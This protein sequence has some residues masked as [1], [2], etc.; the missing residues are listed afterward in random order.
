M[1]VES[2]L[3]EV[4][5]LTESEGLMK[6]CEIVLEV[7]ET[8]LNVSI[9]VKQIKQVI[10][11]M[12]KNAMDAIE[13]VG[14]EYTGLIRITTATENNFV[15]ITITDNGRGWIIIHWY[16]YSTLS[17]PQKRAERASDFP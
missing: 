15:Q 13:E 5:L 11:N 4:V 14:E 2:L 10:L 12:V 17:S 9:D 16:V 6:G 7:D 8:P 1:T 3:K